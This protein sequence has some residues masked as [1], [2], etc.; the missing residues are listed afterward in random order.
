MAKTLLLH[1]LMGLREMM[2]WTEDAWKELGDMIRAVKNGWHIE[3]DELRMF[4]DRVGCEVTG[5]CVMS[6]HKLYV[7]ELRQRNNLP[8]DD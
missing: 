2:C 1:Y 6:A 3:R 4:A 5:K 7:A 8:D